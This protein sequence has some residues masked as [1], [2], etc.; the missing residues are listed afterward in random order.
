MWEAEFVHARIYNLFGGLLRTIL[1]TVYCFSSEIELLV[2][3]L[4]TYDF[5]MRLNNWRKPDMA[6]CG[7][8]LVRLIGLKM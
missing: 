1:V 8:A 6:V 3:L 7:G 5:S 2:R 4:K